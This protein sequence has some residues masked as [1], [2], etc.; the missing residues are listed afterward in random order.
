TTVR[1][2]GSSPAPVGRMVTTTSTRVPGTTNP[3]TPITSST[4]TDMARMPVGI[5][6]GSPAPASTGASLLSVS[7]SFSRTVTTRPRF[8]TASVLDNAPGTGLLDGHATSFTS[9]SVRRAPVGRL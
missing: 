1:D 5:V 8:T 4:L 2:I 3:A 7:G 9:L 6:G